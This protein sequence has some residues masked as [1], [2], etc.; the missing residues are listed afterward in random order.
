MDY[1]SMDELSELGELICSE[2]NKHREASVYS[3]HSNKEE[4]LHFL[5]LKESSEE[6]TTTFDAT[7]D[8]TTIHDKDL[9]IIRANKAFYDEYNIDKKQLNKKNRFERYFDAESNCVLT[10]CAVSLKPECEECCHYDRHDKNETYFISAYPLLDEQGALQGIIRQYKNITE[11]K[12]VDR[13]IKKAE[14]FAEGLIETA[15]DAIISIDEEG[16]VKLWNLSAEKI[17]GYSRNEIMGKSITAIIPEK[18]KKGP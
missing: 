1:R 2:I 9:N 17:F 16:I 10:R 15:Q 3:V 5:K 8:V 7:T 4:D 13:K 14:K 6:W 12:K 11:R 18:H